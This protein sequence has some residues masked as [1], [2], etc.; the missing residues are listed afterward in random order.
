MRIFLDANIIYS[1][2]RST[3]GA[4]YAVF[5]IAKR[6]KIEIVSSRLALVEAERN[7]Y[8]KE[9]QEVIERF[10][11]LIKN[12][13]VLSVESDKAKSRYKDVI[14][15]KDAPI[16]YGAFKSGSSYL[17]TLDRKRFFTKKVKQTKFSF[18]IMTPG[19]FIVSI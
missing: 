12:I 9:N 4:S 16:L 10:Y 11:S 8:E 3:K 15:E 14:E 5:Q 17:L 19:D 7:L 2:S 13:D 1:A 6:G 18:K